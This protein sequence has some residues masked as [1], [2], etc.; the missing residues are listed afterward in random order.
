MSELSDALEAVGQLKAKT[1][2]LLACDAR[3]EAERA[4][5]SGPPG[6]ETLA[7]LCRAVLALAD[8]GKIVA[9]IIPAD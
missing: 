7:S 4:T 1:P 5:L 9:G 6:P 2:D 3:M 8:S